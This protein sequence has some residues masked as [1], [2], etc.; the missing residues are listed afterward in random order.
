MTR[1]QWLIIALV[2]ALCVGGATAWWL[3][4]AKPPAD[5]LTL[6]GNV[7]LRQVELA[8][9]DSDRILSV[10]AQEGDRLTKGQVVARLDVSRLAPEAAQVE[11]EADAQRALVAKLHAGNR[12]QEIAQ[13]RAALDAAS[14]DALDARGQYQRAASLWSAAAGQ[15]A[16]SRQ[17]VDN[18]RAAMDAADAKVEAQRQAYALERIGFRREDIEQAD[19]QLRADEAQ[20][21]V[22]KQELADAA[23]VSPVAGVV[24]AR[25]MEPGE[26]ASPQR[27]VFTI[28]ETDPK[29]VRAYVSESDLPRVHSGATAFVSVDG[30]PDR[31]FKGWV[32]FISSVAEF[33]PKT[34]QTP[35]LRT[36]LVYEIRVF[37]TDPGDDLKLGMPATVTLRLEPLA[38]G[39]GS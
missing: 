37:V 27:P 35:E 5:T 29:W 32:G 30:F 28:A 20:L 18:A 34:V 25:L 12:P 2:G 4:H 15:A 11:A 33:T 38:P 17:D 9:N 36:S 26:M 1:R 3:L 6:Y 16:V 21:A 10:D 31:R 19:A 24:R 7:D 39:S 8:F 23:L 13:A 22:L 14:A